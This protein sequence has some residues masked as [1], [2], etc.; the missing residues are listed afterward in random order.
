MRITGFFTLAA[1]HGTKYASCQAFT[2]RTNS[3]MF[4]LFAFAR[5]NNRSS[6]NSSAKDGSF[7]HSTS[8][9]ESIP[10]EYPRLDIVKHAISA[11]RKASRITTHLQPGGDSNV[12]GITKKDASPVT[13]GD[14]AA[15]AIVLKLLETQRKDDIFIAEESSS[16]LSDDLSDEIMNVLDLCGLKN[17][18]VIGDVE[19]LKRCI[20]MG[21]SYKKNGELLDSAK[22]K[23]D[24]KNRVWCL[25]P[26]D[27]TRGFLRGK[28]EGGMSYICICFL[29]YRQILSYAYIQTLSWCFNIKSI[30]IIYLR[31]QVNIASHLR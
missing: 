3:H 16:N 10:D 31:P 21:Q 1:Q 4:S 23:L 18:D 29:S 27:G 5:S 26:I 22:E 28:R 19:E 24:E 30:F 7:L 25:D 11:I 20:D 2:S 15:Q 6:K 9:K 13:I 17:E 14:F 8:K 12:S